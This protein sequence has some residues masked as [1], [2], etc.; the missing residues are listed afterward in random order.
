MTATEAEQNASSR[1]GLLDSRFLNS[2]LLL[3]VW[4]RASYEPLLERT[5]G[6]R[7]IALDCPRRDASTMPAV[8]SPEQL[9]QFDRDGF[10]V[11]PGFLAPAE[12]SRLLDRA[13]TLLADMSL[14]GHPMVRSS[15]DVS[16]IRRVRLQTYR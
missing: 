11:V 3:R 4:P 10:L 16:L 5:S 1:F 7:S 8:L 13:K 12:T 6:R 9:A 15:A 14:D 2:V